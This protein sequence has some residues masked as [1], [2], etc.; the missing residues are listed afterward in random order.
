MLSLG[1]P[2]ARCLFWPMMSEDL[3]LK[4]IAINKYLEGL[5]EFKENSINFAYVGRFS[6]SKGVF[7]LLDAFIF[8]LNKSHFN[9]VFMYLVGGGYEIVKVREI[10]KKFSNIIVIEW[11]TPAELPFIY[12][13]MDFFVNPSHYDGFSTVA[14][15]AASMSLPL[16]LTKM[17]GCV[18]DLLVDNDNGFV[19]EAKSS[20]ELAKAIERIVEVGKEKR[21]QMGYQSRMKFLEMSSFQHHINSINLML[22]E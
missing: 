3:M 17:V 5:L 21:L 10:A 1:L 12:S 16:I 2:K 7:T 18:P 9:N 13:R 22:N 4:P 15:E 14:C 19:V 11:V 6:K 20:T 8:L